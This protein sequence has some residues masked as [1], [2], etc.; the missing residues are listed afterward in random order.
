M[1][2]RLR[3]SLSFLFGQELVY[4]RMNPRLVGVSWQ[5]AVF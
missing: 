5:C 3:N 1:N 4:E 2:L